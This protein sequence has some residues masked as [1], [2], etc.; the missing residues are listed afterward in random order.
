MDE[1]EDAY[2]VVHRLGG[3]VQA[4]NGL[5]RVSVARGAGAFQTAFKH[6]RRAQAEDRTFL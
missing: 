3:K 2:W 5:G 1:A 4:H 6:F